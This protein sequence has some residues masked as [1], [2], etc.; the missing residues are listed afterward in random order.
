[1]I[2]AGLPQTRRDLLRACTAC[3]A[4]AAGRT[5]G[6]IAGQRFV[7]IGSRALGIAAWASGFYWPRVR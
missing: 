2:P 1:M 7:T 5:P 3:F 6:S 4:A